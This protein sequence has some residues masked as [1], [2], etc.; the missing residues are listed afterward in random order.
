MCGIFLF[1]KNNNLNLNGKVFL[2]NLKHRGPDFQKIYRDNDVEIGHTLLSIRDTIDNSIQPVITENGR[3]V[4]S[5]NGQIYNLKEIINKFN[6]PKDILLDTTIISILCN[7]LGV[8]FIHEIDGMFALIIYDKVDKKIISV[9][10]NT[11]Q[12]PLYYYFDNKNF[13]L[14][15]EIDPI[16]K[17]IKKE[18]VVD[19]DFNAHLRFMVSI[20]EKTIYKNIFKFLPGQKIEF[21]LT[22]NKLSKSFFNHNF[23]KKEVNLEDLLSKTIKDHLQTNQKLIINLSGGIDSN[24]ILHEAIKSKKIEALSTRFETNEEKYNEDFFTAKKVCQDNG[25]KFHE[26]FISKKDFIDNFVKTFETIE[27]INGNINNPAYFLTYKF[28]KQNNFRTVLSGDGGDEIFVGYSWFFL[29]NF[30]LF[31]YFPLVKEIFYNNSKF[32]KSHFYF[33]K[34]FNRYDSLTNLRNYFDEEAIVSRY[35]YIN[36]FANQLEEFKKINFPSQNNSLEISNLLHTQ[37]FW[38]SDEIFNRADKLAMH[39]SIES[40]APLADYNLRL[41]TMNK[42]TKKNFYTK[43]NKTIVRNIY[44]NKLDPNVFKTKK[45]WTVPRDWILDKKFLDI[46]L[47]IIPNKEIYNIKWNKIRNDLYKKNNLI[48]MRS[49]Y[50]IISLAIILNKNNLFK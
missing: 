1:T 41:N 25:V 9:R 18:I 37:F 30:K 2:Q 12:K 10:D 6:L 29:N 31:K 3:Y 8:N 27:D 50:P 20:G 14:S 21:D 19:L 13:I 34:Q 36:K 5:F 49:L 23:V 33:I 40:R 42:L 46:I 15:S 4:I 26:N 48:M 7:K 38:L 47:D 16:L 28:I 24:I 45:G 43:D 22:D 32:L 39:H 11:G 44:N 35:L 17:S